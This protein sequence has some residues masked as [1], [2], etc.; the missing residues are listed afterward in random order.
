M[1]VKE[2]IEAN[3]DKTTRF[4]TEDND[5]LIGLPHPYTVPCCEN[6]FQEMYYWDVYFTNIGLIKS[7]RLAQAKNNV[8]N[9]CYLINKYGFMPNGN[10]TFYLSRSQPPFLS[11]MVRCIYEKTHDIQWL[12]TCYNALEKEYEFWENERQTSCGLNR[13]YGNFSY[14]ELIKFSEVLCKRFNIEEPEDNSTAEH[15]GKAMYSFAESGWDCN[16]RMGIDC[17]NYAWVDLN[18]LLFGLET[19]MAFF[20]AELKNA[21]EAIWSEKA[22]NRRSLMTKLLW[23]DKTGAFCDYNFIGGKQSDIISIA[24][25]YPLFS[26]VC[27]KNQADRTVKLLSEIEAE[28]GVACCEKRE[29]LFGLQWDYP[30]GWACLQYIVVHGL[31][32]YGYREEALR[33]AK[34]YKRLVENVFEATGNLWEKYDV[35][36]GK[37]SNNKEYKTPAMMGWTAGV[38]VDFC[39]LAEE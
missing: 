29:N 6:N 38:Y 24:Q 23:N 5:T 25:F 14:D 33:I 28:F 9:M 22:E 31:L 13:Y 39:S 1:N 16:S 27:T 7:G 10:R 34:K 15:Y 35:T 36:T 12:S 26:G 20:S 4:F 21:N 2:Y 18:S 8:D 3:W 37:V 32:R 30:N 19:D 11:Q 17:Y